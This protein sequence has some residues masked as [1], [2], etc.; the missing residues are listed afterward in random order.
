MP[1]KN[2]ADQDAARQ[3]YREA[4]PEK[5]YEQQHKAYRETAFAPKHR[6]AWTQDE[7]NQVLAHSIPDRE[8]S[9]KIGRSLNAIHVRRT[10]ITPKTGEADD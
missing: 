7:D 8:L 4:N 6:L 10:R 9:A 3:R 1:Y 2:K 5:A